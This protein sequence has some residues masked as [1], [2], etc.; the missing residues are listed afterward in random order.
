MT[1]FCW[2]NEI[3]LG[4][5]PAGVLLI[6]KLFITVVSIK[7]LRNT[8]ISPIIKRTYYIC[9]ISAIISTL[10]P[11]FLSVLCPSKTAEM[12]LMTIWAICLSVMSLSII[13]MLLLRIHLTFEQTMF[14]MSLSQKLIIIISYTITVILTMIISGLWAFMIATEEYDSLLILQ[15]NNL[16]FTVSDNIK[17]DCNSF[18]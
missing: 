1:A 17:Y 2:V 3:L 18:Q 11:T 4:I 14:K 8:K 12:Y 9:C 5:I 10:I 7:Q 13:L 16:L 6:L 15:T